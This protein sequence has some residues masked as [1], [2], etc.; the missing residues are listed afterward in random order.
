MDSA[1]GWIGQIIEWV[2]SFIPHYVHVKATHMGIMFYR[3]N[4][5]TLDPGLHW[6]LPFWSE[7]LLYPIKRQT[8]NLPPQVLTTID[9]ITIL[10]SVVVTYD[11]YDIHKAMVDTYDFEDTI[12]EVSQVAVKKVITVKTFTNIGESDDEIDR[13][14]CRRIRSAIRVYGVRVIEAAIT[15][16]G[17][18][19]IYRLVGDGCES[20]HQQFPASFV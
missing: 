7:P 15:D 6:Y 20:K 10:V 14:L 13:E 9:N 11:I 18:T 16:L 2:G 19:R 1:F 3:S 17:K 12:R 4:T 8:L 5:I